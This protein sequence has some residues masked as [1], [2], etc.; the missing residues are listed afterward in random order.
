MTVHL[1]YTVGQSSHVDSKA[2]APERQVGDAVIK[3]TSA[4]AILEHCHPLR[5]KYV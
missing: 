3:C 1:Q 5:E 4:S 2:G